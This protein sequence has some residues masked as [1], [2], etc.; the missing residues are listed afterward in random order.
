MIQ[1]KREEKIGWRRMRKRNI[2]NQRKDT[3]IGHGHPEKIIE[4]KL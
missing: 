3:E 4:N 1:R 2:Q